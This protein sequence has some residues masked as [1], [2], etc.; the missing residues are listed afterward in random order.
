MD[1]ILEVE[2]VVMEKGSAMEDSYS[3]C[4]EFAMQAKFIFTFYLYY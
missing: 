1:K 3:S 4:K 2:V